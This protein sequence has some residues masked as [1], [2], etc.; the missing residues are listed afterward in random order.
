MKKLLLVLALAWVPSWVLAVAPEDYYNAGMDLFKNHDYEKAIQYFHTAVEERPDYWQAYQSLGSAYY[1]NG[2]VTAALM[3]MGQS[4]KLHPDN[5]D[6]RKFV[7]KIKNDSPW[8]S[9]GFSMGLLSVIALV[10]SL[11]NAAWTGYWIW[12]YKP[13]SS[14]PPSKS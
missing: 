5:P 1:Q 7:S 12:R 10:L 13:F 8:A 3:A 4:L 2:N 11:L 9:N 6:L 14:R